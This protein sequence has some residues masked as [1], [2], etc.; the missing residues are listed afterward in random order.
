MDQKVT[1]ILPP[2]SVDDLLALSAEARLGQVDFAS[3]LVAAPSND[4]PLAT[5]TSV[6][7]RRRAVAVEPEPVVETEPAAVVEP[8]PE[9]EAV[10][11]PEPAPTPAKPAPRSRPK[12]AAKATPKAAA[13]KPAAR[14]PAASRRK[15]VPE[16]TAAEPMTEGTVDAV[17]AGAMGTDHRDELVEDAVL[18]DAA[19]TLRFSTEPAP[20]PRRIARALP[21]VPEQAPDDAYLGG[22]VQEVVDA[23][24]ERLRDAENAALQHVAALETE[25]AR[26]AELLT[27][28]AELDAELI[29]ITARREAHAI[30]SA[31]R[32][33]A[34]LGGQS[35]RESR[36]LAEISDAVSRL[37]ES[38][39]STLAPRHPFSTQGDQA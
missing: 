21:V 30:I 1:P 14:K 22:S 13:A 32:S 16:A 37:A 35:P 25:A 38:I 5:V 34:G 28:Q 24:I 15:P 3:R 39:E 31:A 10:V 6:D 20:S 11:E 26:R 19:P 7:D 36:Q 8:E 29:R 12:P 9:P 27:A 18:A 4:A 17:I 2:P 23:A 33:Q